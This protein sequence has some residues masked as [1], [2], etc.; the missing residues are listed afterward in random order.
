MLALIL[1]GTFLIQPSVPGLPNTPS[2][3]QPG[4][5]V[6]PHGDSYTVQPTIPG[7]PIA[8]PGAPAYIVPAQPAPGGPAIVPVP[9]LPPPR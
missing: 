9:A 4:Y 2:L 3:T 6:T 1:F 8:S 5:L 7:L